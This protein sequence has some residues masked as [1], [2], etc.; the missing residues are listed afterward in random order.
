MKYIL[1]WVLSAF[2]LLSALAFL[3]NLTFVYMAIL[4]V[5]FLPLTVIQ[6]Y[7]KEQLRARWLRVLIVCVLFLTAIITLPTNPTSSPNQAPPPNTLVSATGTVTS[8]TECISTPTAAI[9][10]YPIATPTATSTETQTAPPTATPIPEIS[11]PSAVSRF[12][13]HY[14][15]VGQA[16][17]SLII[18]DDMT[19]LIDGGNIDDSSKL[20][21]YL[22]KHNV[23]HLDYVI[24]T[25]AH[26]DHIGG[27]AGA[28]HFASVGVVYCP[29]TNYSSEA[30]TNFVKAAQ[31]HGVSLTVP[32]VGTTFTL[33]S[34]SCKILAVNTGNSTNNTSIV[35]RVTY[36]ETSFLFTGDTEREVELS[37]LNRG[38][39]LKSTV[40]KVG[41]H[42]A[43]TSTSYVW[44]REIMPE[45]AV[46]S[47]GTDNSYG[48]PTEAV[49]SRLRDA[50]VN[51]FRTDMQGDIICSSDG[52]TVT[53]EVGRNA[54]VD[55]LQVI[56]DNY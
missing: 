21:A 48:H 14:L 25:H 47:V 17:A 45:Y 2:F 3:P 30:F 6:D 51:T 55:T 28:L 34:A 12:E 4:G 40:L 54:N 32:D 35:L 24:G 22:K 46:I 5:F 42:G 18:C 44:L 53:F 26:E 10:L 23:T 33:G 50:E 9:T 52:K 56:M 7:I 11:T 49:L 39:E 15:D 1:M 19:M 36:G 29:V 20:Y 31:K 27:I 43:N 38:E 16:D 13:V 41:H 8:A 37:L